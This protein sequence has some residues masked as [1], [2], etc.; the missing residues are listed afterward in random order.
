MPKNGGIEA[1]L[2]AGLEYITRAGFELV[3]RVDAGDRC[4]PDRWRGSRPSWIRAPDVHLVGSNVEWRRDDDSLAF[5]M[6]LPSTH[7]EISRALHHKVCLLHPTVMFRT[8]LV[9]TVGPYSYDYPGRGRLRVLLA[10][11]TPIPSGQHPRDAA[12]AALPRRKL[13]IRNSASAAP[14]ASFASSS[15]TSA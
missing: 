13:S 4:A 11:R 9:H 1:A 3:A 7:E 12:H 2:N 8:S 5:D 6:S 10:H 14:D 15:S